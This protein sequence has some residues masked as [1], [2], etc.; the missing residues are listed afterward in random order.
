[1]TDHVRLLPRI[2]TLVALT[3]AVTACAGSD[4]T[5]T[6]SAI[7]RLL[8][9]AASDTSGQLESFAGKLPKGLPVEPPRYPGSVL[10]V[11]SRQP[12]PSS[13]GAAAPT[14]A[15]N[16]PQPTLFLLVYDTGDSREKVFRFYQDA[17]DKDPWQLES[18]LSTGDLDTLQF[19][20]VT[21]GDITGAVS[22]ST[23]GEDGRTSILTSLQDA[24]AF[25]QEQ[26]PFQPA[27]SLPLPKEFPGDI[28]LYPGGVTTSTAFLR[29]PA[30][31]SFL[32]IFITTDSQAEIASF[33]RDEFHKLGWVVQEGAPLGLENRIDFHDNANDIQGDLLADRYA[34]DH[35]YTEVRVQIRMNPAR[36]PAGAVTPAPTTPAP[37]STPAP[38]ST[39]PSSG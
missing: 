32:L 7:H 30:N 29:E 2:A 8:L 11:S 31:E 23:G 3:L 19:S 6:A 35:T 33:Y 12:S 9:A 39:L 20:D 1:L 17:L 10:I 25:R 16:V 13:G 37:A 24:G 38:T 22:I 26:P 34:R 4:N 27:A 21:D 28:P 15:A 18:S 5:R 14:P 36:T